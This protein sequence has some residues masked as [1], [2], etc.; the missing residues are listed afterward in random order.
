MS[1]GI[2]EGYLPVKLRQR[3]PR[4][5]CRPLLDAV[6][7]IPCQL[8]I[9]T[10]CDGGNGEPAHSNLAQHGKGRSRKA[11][12]VFI[13][14]A[15][16]SCHRELDQGRMF[17]RQTKEVYWRRAHDRTIL[18]LFRRGLVGVVPQAIRNAQFSVI[19]DALQTMPKPTYELSAI[20]VAKLIKPRKRSA[21]TGQAN[22]RSTESPSKIFKRRQP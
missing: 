7:L 19:V 17:D 21:K 12:D 6:Y 2:K 14:S 10:V 9:E 4:W 8:Q 22:G 3:E 13:C 18:E 1:K 5:E 15:C 20:G 16:R 11:H